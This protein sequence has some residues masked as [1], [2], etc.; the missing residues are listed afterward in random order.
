MDCCKKGPPTDWTA[1]SY[2]LMIE[3]LVDTYCRHK[4]LKLD[5]GN[6]SF[7]KTSALNWV[8]HDFPQGLMHS[9]RPIPVIFGRSSG[10]RECYHQPLSRPWT[11]LGCA[12]KY[13]GF[14]GIWSGW[15]FQIFFV[16]HNIWDNPSHWLL[17]FS[18][19]LKPPTSD[20]IFHRFHV[21]QTTKTSWKF[22]GIFLWKTSWGYLGNLLNL[23]TL[24]RFQVGIRTD[25]K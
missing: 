17:Y 5:W 14:T 6:C 13:N 1:E 18:R 9:M 3:L 2:R 19:W 4:N 10:L 21:I 12:K 11:N 7:K 15:L 20:G 25:K 8:S 22:H 24:G 23:I 16:F